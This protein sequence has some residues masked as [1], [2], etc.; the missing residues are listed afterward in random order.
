MSSL[1]HELTR[2]SDRGDEDSEV[3][4]LRARVA[5]LERQLVELEAWSNSTLGA[6]QERL[7]WLDRWQ[8]DLNAVMDRPAATR[9][10]TVLR[11]VRAVYRP[12]RK[13]KRRML[14]A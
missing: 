12:L 9:V 14:G 4:A 2:A 6:A 8:L 13:A 7:Y 11:G 5:E 1:D 10:R 3:A